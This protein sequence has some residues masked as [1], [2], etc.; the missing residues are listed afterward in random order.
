MATRSQDRPL[1]EAGGKGLFTKELDT[2]LMMGGIDLAVHSAKDLPTFLPDAITIAGYLP[3]ED[4]RDVWISPVAPSPRELPEGAVVG[5]ASLRRGAMLRRMRPDIEIALIRGNVQTRLRKIEEGQFAGTLLALAGLRRLGLEDRATYTI[6]IEDF[7]PAAGQGAIG[8]TARADDPHV[9]KR[10][11]RRSCAKPTGVALAAERAFLTALDGSCRTPIGAHATLDNGRV[12]LRGT[13]LRPDGSQAFDEEMY[14]DE[15]DAAA[16]GTTVGEAIKG[17]LPAGILRRVK[18]CPVIERICAARILPRAAGEGDH[19]ER[20][21][22][23]LPLPRPSGVFKSTLRENETTEIGGGSPLHHAAH[24]PP[25]PRLRGR[26][27]AARPSVRVL[28]TRAADDAAR[29]ARRCSPR[30]TLVGAV[31]GDRDRR[32]GAPGRRRRRRRAGNERECLRG[33]AG[34]RPCETEARRLMPLYLV[35]ERTVPSALGAGLRG[36]RH[37]RGQRSGAVARP[38]HDDL[39]GRRQPRLP[40]GARPQARNRGGTGRCRPMLWRCMEV[41][42][43]EAIDALTDDAERS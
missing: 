7:L 23:G 31:A 28:L 41:Y 26:M 9:A 42:R 13:V 15:A 40:R 2:S 36:R 32:L 34:F 5:T 18:R 30:A 43:A 25:P 39:A 22:R 8:I 35:G 21:W 27:R 29:T 4:V 37:R 33:R 6:P 3:R 14:G 11:W 12:T 19:A 20:W 1:S 24:G 38:R 17:R 16:I 10:C